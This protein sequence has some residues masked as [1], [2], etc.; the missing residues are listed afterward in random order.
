[1]EKL[2]TFNGGSTILL[3]PKKGNLKSLKNYRLIT[4]YNADEKIYTKIITK[5]LQK[6]IG[7]LIDIHQSGFVKNGKNFDNTLT[8]NFL[9]EKNFIIPIETN[10][11]LII[12]DQEKYYYRFD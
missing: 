7:I 4:L 3:T 12:L 10:G 1:M 11:C 8:A 2:N 6:V 9:F 5:R